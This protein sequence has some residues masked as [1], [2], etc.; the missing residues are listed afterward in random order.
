[1]PLLR[2]SHQQIHYE[3]IGDPDLPVITFLNGLTQNARLW[4]AYADHFV[5]RGYRVLAYD[6]LGQ[7]RSSKPVIDIPLA[8]HAELLDQLLTHLQIEKTHLASISFGGTIALDFAIRFGH[9][10]HSLVVMSSFAELTPQLELLGAV[11][12]EGLTDVGLPY[13]QSMLYPM[14]M[15]SDWIAANRER[16]PAMKRA[17]Y[18]SNDGY[19][20]QNLMES[21]AAFKPLTADLDRIKVPTL[22]LNGEFDFFTPRACHEVIRRNIANSRLVIMPRAYHAF[23]LEMPALTLRQLEVF[24]NQIDEGIW[25]GDQSVWLANDDPKIAEAWLPIHGD[26]MRAAQPATPMTDSTKP[27]SR[28]KPTPRKKIP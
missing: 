15:S 8:S 21:F 23:T 22:I 3:L 12:L 28:R 25:Q 4:T 20:M 14:N 9:R 1:M 26:W 7:G 18:I 27:A 16:I 5:P 24:L 17:G 2:T 6:M 10:L 13:L 19:A 11:M